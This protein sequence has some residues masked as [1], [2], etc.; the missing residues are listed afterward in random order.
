MLL[1]VYYHITAREL[2]R[3]GSKKT[4]GF[5]TTVILQKLPSETEKERPTELRVQDLSDALTPSSAS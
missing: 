5:P 4:P 3:A 1:T 2:A